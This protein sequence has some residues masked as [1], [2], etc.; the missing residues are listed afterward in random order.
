MFL[1][2]FLWL[3]LHMFEESLNDLPGKR[4]SVI[5]IEVVRALR[6]CCL[7]IAFDFYH[8]V[9]NLD[10]PLLLEFLSTFN[11]VTLKLSAVALYSEL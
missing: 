3:Y 1:V 7:L 10:V 9:L 11:N 8:L 5:S 4:S 6:C 2:A